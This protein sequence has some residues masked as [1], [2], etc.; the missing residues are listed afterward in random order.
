MASELQPAS[1]IVV[2]SAVFR[3]GMN[4]DALWDFYGDAPQSPVTEADVVDFL[5]G[6]VVALATSG[7][8]DDSRL[9]AHAGFLLGWIAAQC[10]PLPPRV[11]RTSV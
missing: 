9:R 6:N 5:H 8:L 11:E 10:L 1:L 7:D 2:E 4:D 3:D